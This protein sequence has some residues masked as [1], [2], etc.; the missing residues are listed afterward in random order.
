M[1]GLIGSANFGTFA[2]VIQNCPSILDV[3]G[4][5]EKSIVEN[6]ILYIAQYSEIM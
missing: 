1:F 5:Q 4:K 2:S 6:V 3:D